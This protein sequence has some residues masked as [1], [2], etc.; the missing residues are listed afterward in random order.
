MGRLMHLEA[1]YYIPDSLREEAS[2]LIK[3]T[4]LVPDLF[5]GVKNITASLIEWTGSDFF[6]RFFVDNTIDD[7][8]NGVPMYVSISDLK[9]LLSRCQTV[10]DFH[11][12]ANELLPCIYSEEPDEA[13]FEDIEYAITEL[14]RIIPRLEKVSL[15]RG[16]CLDIN[17][18]ATW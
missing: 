18:V 4:E 8:A 15:S 14:E 2:T 1:V 9:E 7:E 3:D 11:G 12:L 5:K 16:M 13:Y 6:H 10:R 17:Y